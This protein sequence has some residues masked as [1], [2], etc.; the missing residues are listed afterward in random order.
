[1]TDGNRYNGT[2]REVD[3][4]NEVD[5]K[6]AETSVLNELCN[7]RTPKKVMLVRESIRISRT[8]DASEYKFYFHFEGDIVMR[9]DFL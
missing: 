7:Y 3:D 2:H 6:F 1:M 9:I 8:N 5:S 4:I